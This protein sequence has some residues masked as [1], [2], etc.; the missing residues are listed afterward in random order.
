MWARFNSVWH[1]HT[2]LLKRTAYMAMLLA[3]VCTIVLGS[4]ISNVEAVQV[5]E[6]A[7]K[8]RAIL[9]VIVDDMIT[10]EAAVRILCTAPTSLEHGRACED[11]RGAWGA[12][13][14]SI[15]TARTL[16]DSYDETGRGLA[17]V[18]QA[19]ARATGALGNLRSALERARETLR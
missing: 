19:L 12:L 14:R 13:E 15:K 9:N 1:A 11:A 4:C 8:S 3:V 10:L 2:V 5:R 6:T 16:V 18:N 17:L 7:N